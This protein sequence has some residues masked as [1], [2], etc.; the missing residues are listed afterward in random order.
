MCG[1]V[2]VVNIEAQKEKISLPDVHAMMHVQHHRGPDDAGACGFCFENRRSYPAA[3]PLD[4]KPDL[5]LDG[6]IGFNRLSIKDLSMAGHQ[7]MTGL[8]G[9]VILAFNGEIYNDSELRRLLVSKGY[10]FAGTSDTEVV[11]NA[12]LEFGFD[13]MLRQLNG[14]FA[15][16]VVDLRGGKIHIARDRVGIKPLY[17]TFYKGRLAFASELKSIIQLSDFDRELDMD[18]FNGRLVFS[19]PSNKVL[20]SGVELLEPGQAATVSI[21]EGLKF[22]HYYNIDDYERAEGKYN[23]IDEALEHAEAVLRAAA[24][25]QMVSDVK[26]GCQLSGGIDSTIVSYF[27]NMME[28][29]R[30]NDGVSIIDDAGAL[31]EEYYI[32]HVGNKLGLDV[33]KYKLDTDYFLDNYERMIW[34]NDAPVYMP[35]FVCF[36]KLAQRAKEHVTVLLSGEGADEL[37]G[38]YSRFAAGVYQ[39][40]IS[41]IGAHAN[42]LTSYDSYAEYAVK[43]DRTFTHLLSSDWQSPDSLIREQVDR[44]NSFSGSN[45]TKHL[46]FEMTQRLPEGLLRQDKMTMANSIENRVPLLDNEVVDFAMQ[47][48]EEFLV[49]FVD[50]S[51]LKLSDNPFEWVAGKFLFKELCARKFGH[52]FAY[53]KKEVMVLD[54]RSMLGSSGFRERFFDSIYPK[55]KD[56]GLLDAERVRSWYETLSEISD[57]A[58]VSMWRAI[59][60]EVWCQ[61]FLDG[62]NKMAPGGSSRGG[63][64]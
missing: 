11:L 25:R 57:N 18:A 60:L 56:R 49:R 33:H 44:F 34:H 24:A 43:S 17:Y 19:R 7:P 35:Y 28:S 4:L 36:L 55:M 54:Q 8:A 3:D 51:P 39:P 2:G 31:G 63:C 46:K 1:I 59:S 15:I 14:M 21:G 16:V 50:P 42:N 64:S 12:Y 37:A 27:A 10:S 53:R 58:V 22:W 61:L 62:N 40:F 20:L 23:S 5:K 26:V 52:D 47:L 30:L 29:N 45:L 6:I 32:D 9:Q 48:P 41:K 13:E 38:G